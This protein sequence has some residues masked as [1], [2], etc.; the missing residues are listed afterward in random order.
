MLGPSTPPVGPVW[1]KAV[2]GV[3]VSRATRSCSITAGDRNENTER[4]IAVSAR[5]GARYRVTALE[6]PAIMIYGR[7]DID[8]K[9]KRMD[10]VRVVVK[11]NKLV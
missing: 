6:R 10:D 8:E 2:D 5:I 7:V 11:W 4:M 1:I 3:T 9:I